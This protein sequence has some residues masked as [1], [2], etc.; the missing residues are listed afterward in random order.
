MSPQNQNLQLQ[1]DR[2]E[3]GEASTDYNTVNIK[4]TASLNQ[5][6]AAENK[7]TKKNEKACIIQGRKW[8]NSNIQN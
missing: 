5:F 8:L 7:E 2:I 6:W 1:S 4:G 3:K